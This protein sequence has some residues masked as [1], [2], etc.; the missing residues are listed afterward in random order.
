MLG[1]D[2]LFTIDTLGMNE[3]EKGERAARGV[4]LGIRGVIG[5]APVT[6]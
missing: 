6:S 4:K 1:I 3:L 2:W 5:V